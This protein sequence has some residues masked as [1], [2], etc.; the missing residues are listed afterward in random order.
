M[1]G[2]AVVSINNAANGQRVI[3]H[4]G[5]TGPVE[6]STTESV[7]AA[8][9]MRVQWENGGALCAGIRADGRLSVP[10]FTSDPSGLVQGDFWVIYSGG[11]YA[12]HYY[13]NGAVVALSGGGSLPPGATG[14]AGLP[15][16]I[17]L[18]KGSVMR[19]SS[20]TTIG[21]ASAGALA[22]TNGLYSPIG[23]LSADVPS[24][25]N[26]PTIDVNLIL[27]GGTLTLTSG[28]VSY[29]TGVGA[30]TPNTRYFLSGVSGRWTT[31]PTGGSM[32]AVV[33]IGIALDSSTFLV[34]FGMP[35]IL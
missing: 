35:I 17:S 25:P 3:L 26:P 33:P 31:T 28:Q 13:D 10:V 4:P 30:L 9:R 14:Y 2:N 23:V 24:S 15:D 18:A 16:T 27:P 32:T 20:S 6:S 12:I 8:S 34:D 21:L 22:V 1:S 19:S 11:T 29:L 7:V 5:P